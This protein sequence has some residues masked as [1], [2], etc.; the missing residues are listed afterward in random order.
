MNKEKFIASYNESRNGA[1]QFYYHSF[2][3]GFHYSNGVRDCTGAVGAY[4]LVDLLAFEAP[5]H[6]RKSGQTLVMVTLVVKDDKAKLTLSGSGDVVFWTKL[7]DY[8]DMPEGT[9]SFVIADERERFAMILL[10]EY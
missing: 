6:I 4:W 9:W 1:N 5:K 10:T 7:I 8:T 2:V 3:R